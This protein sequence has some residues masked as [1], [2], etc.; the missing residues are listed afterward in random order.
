MWREIKNSVFSL[1]KNL[2]TAQISSWT[3]ELSTAHAQSSVIRLAEYDKT[4]LKN[5]P[6]DGWLSSV[7]KFSEDSLL[8]AKATELFSSHPS[9]VIIRSSISLKCFLICKGILISNEIKLLIFFQKSKAVMLWRHK[10]SSNKMQFIVIA[11]KIVSELQAKSALWNLS[12]E[13]IGERLFPL[14]FSIFNKF[15]RDT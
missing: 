2:N 13:R 14:F 3:G 9:R 15:S 1:K 7:P 5:C 8:M 12:F 6:K 10:I 4:L 11:Y